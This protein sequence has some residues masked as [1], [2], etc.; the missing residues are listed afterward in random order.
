MANHLSGLC[1]DIP[2]PI[3]S[4]FFGFQPYRGGDDLLWALNE[5]RNTVEHKMVTPVGTGAFP[6][7]A[8][9]HGTGFFQMPRPHVW[10]SAKNEMVLITLGAG[11]EF[12]YQFNFRLFVAFGEIEVVK[13]MEVI[14]TLNKIGYKVQSIL[15]SIEAESKRL[16]IIK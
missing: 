10:D 8:Y 11:A 9:V 16:G 3:Q 13:G 12:N 4:L 6:M 2:E 14:Q 7:G 1:R 15:A 5:I